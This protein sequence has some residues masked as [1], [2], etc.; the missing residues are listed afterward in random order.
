MLNILWNSSPV[1]YF[2]SIKTH[3]VKEW[4]KISEKTMETEGKSQYIYVSD[5]V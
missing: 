3:I 5:F 2:G 4:R 1:K